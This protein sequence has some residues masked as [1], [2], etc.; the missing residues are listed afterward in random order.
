MIFNLIKQFP[1]LNENT[2][3][4]SS[5]FGN[6][7]TFMFKRGRLQH[8]GRFQKEGKPNSNVQLNW[9]STIANRG[10]IKPKQDET[11]GKPK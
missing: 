2:N 6:I 10:E 11:P 9:A 1:L 3:K 4:L 7:F 8:D 5:Y